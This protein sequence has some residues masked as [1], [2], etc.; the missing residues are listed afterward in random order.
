MN[1][2]GESEEEKKINR[3]IAEIDNEN[4]LLI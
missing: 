4:S 3:E 1:R 2:D